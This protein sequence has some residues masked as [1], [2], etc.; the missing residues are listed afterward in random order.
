[1]LLQQQPE[2][3]DLKWVLVLFPGAALAFLLRRRAGPADVAAKLL[4]CL[5]LLGAGFFWAAA[6]AHYRLAD[7]LP[8]EW[9]G[10]DVQVIGVIAELPQINERGIRYAFD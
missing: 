5:M 3:P 10:R 2:L 1:M 8:P 4:S 6:F 9:E 7:S